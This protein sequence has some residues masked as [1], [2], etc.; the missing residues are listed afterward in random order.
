[1]RDPP[2]PRNEPVITRGMW[3]HIFFVGTVMAGGTLFAIDASLPGGLIEG[4]RDIRY[5]QTMAFTTLVLFQLLNVF[6][7]R[8]DETSAFTHLFSNRW[9]WGA[10]GLSFA[11][12]L[13]VVYAP[14]LQ[15]AFSTVALSGADW[16]R[17]AA[18]ASTVL[19]ARELTKLVTRWIR[20]SRSR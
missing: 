3:L 2:R 17:C 19:W 12:Q 18:A 11:L 15:Q 13:L 6:N 16:L 8:S 10:I 1:M 4:T 14:I 9:L 7:A 20:P 5:A